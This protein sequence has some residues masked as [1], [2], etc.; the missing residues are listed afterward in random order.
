LIDRD[1]CDIDALQ[2][3]APMLASCYATSIAGR[4]TIGRRKGA[5]LDRI[6]ADPHA[7]WVDMHGPLQAAADGFDLHAALTVQ[8][9]QPEGRLAVAG[10]NRH[11]YAD[12]GIVL[13]RLRLQKHGGHA[14]D[15]LIAGTS[16]AL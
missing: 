8:S 2:D 15:Q 13:P 5:K 11:P 1:H 6:G 9:Q 3:E 12:T 4:Q 16:I 7:P 14:F 10:E